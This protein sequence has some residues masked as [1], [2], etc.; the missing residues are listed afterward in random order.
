MSLEGKNYTELTHI[1]HELLEDNAKIKRECGPHIPGD[2]SRGFNVYV[3]MIVC[4]VWIV[5]MIGILCCC[6]YQRKQQS[7]NASRNQT[8]DKPMVCEY[9]ILIYYIH[10]RKVVIL[11]TYEDF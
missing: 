5:L 8:N 11:H 3:I 4:F 2:L 1:L 9:Y 7:L 6:L 10:D